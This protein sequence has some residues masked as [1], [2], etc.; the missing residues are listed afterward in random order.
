MADLCWISIKK[1]VWGEF[2]SFDKLQQT[3]VKLTTEASSTK[4]TNSSDDLVK[5]LI[6]VH[7]NIAL[8]QILF[9]VFPEFSEDFDI[10]FTIF[11]P[12]D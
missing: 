12:L 6:V 8:N 5:L 2:A 11:S 7:I 4:S 3:T 9:L 1:R 10:I